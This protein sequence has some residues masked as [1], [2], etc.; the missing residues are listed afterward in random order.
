MENL[1]IRATEHTPEI[2][3][4]CRRNRLEI[5]GRSYL[6]DINAFYKPVL[7][8]VKKYIEQ[9]GNEKVDVNVK[10]IYF[11]SGSVKPLMEFFYLLDTA[12]GRGKHVT[13]NWIYDRG[14][15]DALEFGEDFKYDLKTVKFNL[16]PK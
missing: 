12:A 5:K 8:W 14:D 7:S 11:N 16:I 15:E 13:V 10:L 9:L 3:F 6:Q 1:M 2:M 4:D